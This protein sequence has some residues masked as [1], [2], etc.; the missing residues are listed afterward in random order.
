MYEETN[1]YQNRFPNKN[2][3]LLRQRLPL[4]WKTEIFESSAT[5]QER[6]YILENL[7]LK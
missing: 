1:I 7:L 5:L 2:S 3:F 6:T 4:Y